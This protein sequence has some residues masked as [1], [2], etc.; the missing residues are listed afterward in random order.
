MSAAPVERP[1]LPTSF[2]SPNIFR[3]PM[4]PGPAPLV[5]INGWHGIGKETVGECLTLL[6]G[7]EKSLLIDVRS[8]GPDSITGS[9]SSPDSKHHHH[10]RHKH[11][12]NPLLTPEHPRYF[13]FDTD[14]DW[15]PTSVGLA[16]PAYSSCTSRSASFSSDCSIATAST[17][18]TATTSPI[19]TTNSFPFPAALPGVT[20]STP[21]FPPT[22]LLPPTPPAP[23][24]AASTNSTTPT[25]TPCPPPPSPPPLPP[26]LPPPPINSNSNQATQPEANHHPSPQV[27][28]ENLTHVLANPLNLH[29]LVILPAHAPDTPAGR[30]LLH[31]FEAA[32]AR[33]G[34][35]FVC[36]ELRCEMG[37][38]QARAVRCRDGL[39]SRLGVTSTC[40]D[41]RGGSNMDLKYWG[42]KEGGGG[43]C[44]GSGAESSFGSSWSGLGGGV[45]SRSGCGSGSS[46]GARLGDG[47]DSSLGCCGGLGMVAEIEIARREVVGLSEGYVAGEG[48]G[49]SM[50]LPYTGAVTAPIPLGQTIGLSAGIRRAGSQTLAMPGKAGLTVDVT[51]LPAFEAAL[52]IVEFVRTLEAERDAELCSSRDGLAIPPGRSLENRKEWVASAGEAR[53]IRK[54]H[55]PFNDYCRST[56][57]APYVQDAVWGRAAGEEC[58]FVRILAETG[59]ASC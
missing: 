6:L 14:L 46:S 59:R 19:L 37:V 25:Q 36:V 39:G 5:Y 18:H 31:T 12:D 22:P 48:R 2:S 13:S 32:A 28:L 38:Y 3:R 10:R 40:T 49:R 43:F 21:A 35:L 58:R 24:T 56:S 42:V 11:E 27:S 7:K 47:C 29:R 26:P 41:R 1:R 53:P 52:Q 15:D 9:S 45:V 4:D 30:A 57:R 44:S 33:A 54:P 17:T 51:S 16:S 23:P 55:R 8:V 50:S 34:R 20:Q